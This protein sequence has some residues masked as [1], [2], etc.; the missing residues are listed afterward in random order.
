MFLFC[1][2]LVHGTCLKLYE[3]GP[4]GFFLRIQTLPTC[5]ATLALISTMRIYLS[6]LFIPEVSRGHLRCLAYLRI[7]CRPGFCGRQRSLQ[8]QVPSL[9]A[10]S[11][12]ARILR[13]PDSENGVPVQMGV[14]PRVIETGH[15]GSSHWI[16]FGGAFGII[17]AQDGHQREPKDNLD[18]VP[19][20]SFANR[21]TGTRWGAGI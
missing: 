7:A 4:G 18:K 10:N 17:K 20:K 9:P 14:Q 13:S 12:S 5:R 19:Q 15:F 8:R 1:K 16:R 2:L 11:L 21:G 3:T 6:F